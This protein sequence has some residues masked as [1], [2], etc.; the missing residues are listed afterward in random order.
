M[1][2][3]TKAMVLLQC[4]GT[5]SVGDVT[6]ASVEA[7][8][9]SQGL[10]S[11]LHRAAFSGMASRQVGRARRN[12]RPAPASRQNTEATTQRSSNQALETGPLKSEAQGLDLSVNT[13][14]SELRGLS[15]VRSSLL[16][17]HDATLLRNGLLTKV[18]DTAW[19]HTSAWVFSGSLV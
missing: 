10:C 19:M 14:W 15:F 16:P 2:W 17:G 18:R 9:I 4:R 6:T 7:L 13:V 11:R 5:G 8:R 12:G 3:F 1:S